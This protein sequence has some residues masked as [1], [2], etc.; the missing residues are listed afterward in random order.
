MLD[1]EKRK[2]IEDNIGLVYSYIEK[3]NIID[4]DDR[5]DYLHEFCHIIDTCTYDENKGKLS[6]LV[7][8][9][10]DNYAIRRNRNKARIKR[11][12]DEQAIL[13]SL[14]ENWY[15][16]DSKHPTT[17]GEVTPDRHDCFGEIE[18]ADGIEKVK[19]ILRRK[20]EKSTA[21]RYVSQE[22]LFNDLIYAYLH[23]NG[24]VNG[25]ELAEKYN[26]SRQSINSYIK[27]FRRLVEAYIL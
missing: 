26:V 18:L 6:T 12:L 2:L 1:N 3:H 9:S 25:S 20:D 15:L 4:E 21:T 16:S 24:K 5:A 23:N 11:T 14:D 19:G 7:W 10:F 8:R 17:L 27:R 13:P 22:G